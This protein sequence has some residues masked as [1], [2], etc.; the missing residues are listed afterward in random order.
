MRPI[1]TDEVALSVGL[2]VTT[3]NHAKTAESNVMSFEVWS[4]VGPS[5]HALDRGSR[6]PHMKGAVLRAKRGRHRTC[7]DMSIG[8]Y[9]RSDPAGGSTGTGADWDVLD[10]GAFCRHLAN[11]T[12]PSV[13]GGDAALCQ[14]ALTTCYYDRCHLHHYQV[15]VV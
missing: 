6:S 11:T 5:N 12:E 3:V 14:I 15:S 10:E 13:C 1:A 9:T 7:L 8:R 2:S 4:R